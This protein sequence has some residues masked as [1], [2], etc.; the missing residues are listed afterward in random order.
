MQQHAS[1]SGSSAP[2]RLPPVAGQCSPASTQHGSLAHGR[3][4]PLRAPDFRVATWAHPATPALA[5]SEELAG[6]AGSL[7]VGAASPLQ[8]AA[9][10]IQLGSAARRRRP[11]S[12]VAWLRAG[13]PAASSALPQ[14]PASPARSSGLQHPPMLPSSIREAADNVPTVATAKPASDAQSRSPA[15]HACVG[16]EQAAF[17]SP[18]SDDCRWVHGQGRSPE[19]VTSDASP[20]EAALRCPAPSVAASLQSSGSQPSR[21]QSPA[22]PGGAGARSL[23]ADPCALTSVGISRAS[24]SGA[25]TST[26]TPTHAQQ[27]Q[28]QQKTLVQVVPDSQRVQHPVL[29]SRPLQAKRGAPDAT[30]PRMERA[31]CGVR[32]VWVSQESRRHGIAGR[33][34]D[35]VR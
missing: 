12:L 27:R 21:I 33:L 30:P 32:V 15:A 4:P 14:P 22:Q 6:P 18:D 35:A 13:Q 8:T 17:S 24:G 26:L 3:Q 16:N 23:P 2:A 28:Q 7:P 11:N 5:A 19:E 31:H 9:S 20:I 10:T 1:A 25:A 34:L 29:S